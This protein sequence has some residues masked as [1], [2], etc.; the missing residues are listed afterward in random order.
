[1]CG[2]V[3]VNC[4]LATVTWDMKPRL[5]L[6]GIVKSVWIKLVRLPTAGVIITLLRSWIVYMQKGN[7][8]LASMQ[9]IDLFA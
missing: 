8:E 2:I 6:W 3:N 9:F 1:M 5:Y 7:W 4:A